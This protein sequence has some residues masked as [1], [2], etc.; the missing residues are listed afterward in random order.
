MKSLLIWSLLFSLIFILSLDI[1]AQDVTGRIEGRIVDESG[2]AI[3]GAVINLSSPDLQGTRFTQTNAEG[4]FR[5]ILLPPGFYTA[6][7]THIAYRPVT[8]DSIQVRL[9]KTSFVSETILIEKPYELEEVIVNA[10]R[11]PIDPNST[12]TGGNF[13]KDE[14]ES[15]PL[16]RN[17]QDIPLLVPQVNKSYLGDE[18]NY[19]GST[20][21]ENKFYIDGIDVTDPILNYRGIEIPYN[22]L[23]EIEVKTGGYE[24]EYRSSLGGVVNVITPS[25]GNKLSGQVF[26]FYT[27][28]AFMGEPKTD[29]EVQLSSGDF[30]YYDFGFSLGGPF[31]KEK[32]WFNV[33][34]NPK[35]DIEDILI[36][37][38]G[39]EPDKKISHIFA[40]KLSWKISN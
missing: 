31:I 21:H 22:F 35:I 13:T 8:I 16:Q 26:G 28:N 10:K 12:V 27:N 17:Y 24:A 20:G 18:I 19:S 30:T 25:G 3:P 14:I 6:K 5:L 38:I 34:Y 1:S 39:Y 29:T 11:N 4:Y 40:G 2:S 37:G 7:I 15:L 32:L 23:R 33:A 9:G 36:P